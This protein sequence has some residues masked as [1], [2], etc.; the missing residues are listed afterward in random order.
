M[1]YRS[2]ADVAEAVF[3]QSLDGIVL[4]DDHGRILAAN[5]AVGRLT[6]YTADE[7]LRLSIVDLTPAT[8]RAEIAELLQS[9]VREG[10]LSGEHQLE[11]KDGTIIDVE[12]LAVARIGGGLH[13]VTLRDI[14]ERKQIAEERERLLVR[15]QAARAEA[16]AASRSKD[17]FLAVLSHELRTPLNAILGWTRMLRQSPADGERLVHAL[18]VIERNARLQSRLVEGLLDLSSLAAGKLA[19][20]H[21]SVLLDDVLRAAI[22]SVRHDAAQRKIDLHLELPD[23]PAVIDGD[24]T[25]L[26]QVFQN[27]VGNA[28]KF[29]ASGGRVDVTVTHGPTAYDVRVR[30]SGEGIPSEAL[31]R[32]FDRFWQADSS[33]GRLHGGLGLGLAIVRELVRAHG[34]SVTVESAGRGH[35]AT[36]VVRLPHE[37]RRQ[38]A[39]GF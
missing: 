10:T 26:L 31:A 36:F 27:L 20:E 17:E 38:N 3:Q 8:R 25:R 15:E 1:P 11:R 21:E 12:L 6:G 29:T 32:V 33:P 13:L 39:A 34:G 14:T 5:P 9:L 37:E 23:E 2:N 30:D 16:E 7:L 24:H 35:G 18:E 19:L 4:A 22:D 28:L